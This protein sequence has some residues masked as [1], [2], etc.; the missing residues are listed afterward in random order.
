[1]KIGF[2]CKISEFNHKQEVVSIPELNFKSTTVAWLNR[3]HNDAAE[4][5]LWDLLKYNIE[6]AKKAVEYVGNLEEPLKMFRLGSDILPV[7]TEPTWGRFWRDTSVRNYCARELGKVGDLARKTGVR[8]S[9]HPGQFCCLSSDN[10]DIVERSLAEFEYHADV[11]KWMGYGKAF[12]DF[13]I[14]IH[15][16]GRRGPAG[17]RDAYNRLTPEARNTLTIENEENTHGL[18]EC[19]EIA[20]IFPVVLDIHHHWCREGEYIQPTDDR[21][22]RVIDSWRGVRPVAHYSYSRD[23]HLPGDFVHATLPNMKELLESGYK[24]QKLRAHS[25]WYPNQTA[26]AWAL[27]FLKTHDI[28][29]ESKAK[30]LASFELYKQA[31]KLALF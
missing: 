23:E 21:V 25:D 30:N 29:A 26:N 12:Q 27:S 2:A 19:L 1:M 20:D 22:K 4:Q 9:M 6:A 31:K 8:L 14:N 11:A 15:I 10:P 18:A 28:M 7:Y 17:I 5:K 16:S 13:K 3:Q 24:K